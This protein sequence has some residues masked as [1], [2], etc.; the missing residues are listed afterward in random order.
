MSN[1]SH[2]ISCSVIDDCIYTAKHIEG[3]QQ[4]KSMHTFFVDLVQ[5]S[6]GDKIEEYIV[7]P[8]IDLFEGKSIVKKGAYLML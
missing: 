6:D 3:E 8:C 1:Y 5:I 2:Y 4:F 7:K